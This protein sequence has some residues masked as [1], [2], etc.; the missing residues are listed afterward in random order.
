[1][2]LSAQ[3]FA[4]C[5][6]GGGGG[7]ATRTVYVSLPLHGTRAAEGRAAAAGVR[8]ALARSGGRVGDLTIRA[9]YLDD[10]GGGPKWTPVATAVNARR[11]T[12]DSR[13]IGFI[14]D[15]DSGATRVSLP[16]TNQAEIV[17]IS[18]GATAVDLTR[19][20]PSGLGPDRY[21]PSGTRTFARVVPPDDVQARAAEMLAKELGGRLALKAQRLTKAVST[22]PGV[23]VVSTQAVLDQV[24]SVCGGLG[25]P[26]YVTSAGPPFANGYRAMS[27]LLDGIRSAGG[28]GSSRNAVT[29]E[30]LS[31][32][33]SDGDP[34][35]TDVTVHRNCTRGTYR[36]LHPAGA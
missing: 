30:V 1:V 8:R 22:R 14:G 25:A 10:T 26:L 36:T 11:A 3:L 2:L 17:Q 32:F 4:G 7:P 28:D 34:G 21:R 23:P 15:L 27:A 5:G 33:D 24:P 31:E 18:P 9:I 35:R 16:I 6:G 12:E 29:N 20:T 13:T 19:N